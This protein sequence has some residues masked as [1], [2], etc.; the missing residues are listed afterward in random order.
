VVNTLAYYDM[1]KNIV[2]KRFT[3]HAF[4]ACIRKLFTAI[5]YGAQHFAN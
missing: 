2:V 1:A 3:V 5:I 4:G